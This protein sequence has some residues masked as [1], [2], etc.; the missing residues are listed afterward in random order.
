MLGVWQA[1]ASL[2]SSPMS[3]SVSSALRPKTAQPRR[4]GKAPMAPGCSSGRSLPRRPPLTLVIHSVVHFLLLI[5]F[6]FLQPFLLFLVVL[7]SALVLLFRIRFSVLVLLLLLRG[8]LFASLL[9]P[10]SW[11]GWRKAGVRRQLIPP[12]R[13]S[14]ESRGA[15]GTSPAR[16]HRTDLGRRPRTRVCITPHACRPE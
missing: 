2:T 13:C 3:C 10:V 4:E 8:L 15:G 16:N 12:G 5:R 9:P 7:L 1:L 14:R 6:F 11:G